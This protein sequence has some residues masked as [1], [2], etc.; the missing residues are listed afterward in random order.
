MNYK[1]HYNRLI[2]RAKSRDLDCYKEKHHIIPKCMG[3]SDNKDNLVDLTPREHFIAHLLL[4]K[5]YPDKISLANAIQMM[6]IQSPNQNRS[7]NRMYGWLKEKF[8]EAQ[9]KNQ[10][11]ELNSQYGTI[12]ICSLERREN[13]KIKR[14]DFSK[15]IDKG[16][17]R[18]RNIWI[19]EENSDNREKIKQEKLNLKIEILKE[20]YEIYNKYGFEKFKKIV[21]YKYSVQ[22]L[23]QQ[24]KKYLPNFEP[25]N[26]RKRGEMLI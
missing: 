6:C 2:K 24:F 18:G 17:I 4:T 23:V 8:S 19:R 11:G 3:G 1:L 7:M 13:K 16:W 21:D 9:S 20:Q 26:G 25:Q 5:I 14:E 10:K 22:N 15:W 12:W